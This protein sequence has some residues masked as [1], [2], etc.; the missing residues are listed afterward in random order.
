MHERTVVTDVLR[1]L[2]KARRFLHI[3][4]GA[5]QVG[6][7]TASLQIAE[8]WHGTVVRANADEPLPPGP[9]WI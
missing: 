8:H 6:K 5:R 4:V 7:T 1:S 9:E 3:V 2:Q